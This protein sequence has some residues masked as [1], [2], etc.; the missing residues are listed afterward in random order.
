MAYKFPKVKRNTDGLFGPTSKAHFYKPVYY[1][2]RSA[3]VNRNKNKWVLKENEQ[4]EVFRISD[5]SDWLCKSNK[6]LF[7]ILNNGEIKLGE[8]EERLSFFKKPV[9]V[10]DPWHGFPVNSG[11]Y[12]PSTELVDKWLKDKIIDDRIHIKI[13]KGQL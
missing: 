6:G 8:N 9:N 11:E 3:I 1:H 13:L 2:N 4:F 7:S 5:E 12:E 10:T